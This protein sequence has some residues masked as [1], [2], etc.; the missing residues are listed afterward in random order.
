MKASENLLPRTSRRS[1]RKS[2]QSKFLPLPWH[3]T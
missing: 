3:E 1:D 2:L